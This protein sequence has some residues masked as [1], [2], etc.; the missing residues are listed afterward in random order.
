MLPDRIDLNLKTQGLGNVNIDSHTTNV[1]GNLRVEGETDLYNG[2]Y[3]HC[4]LSSE[5]DIEAIDS[6][7]HG[8]EL[9]EGGTSLA[10]KY[11][12]RQVITAVTDFNTLTTSGNYYIQYT[13]GGNQ[14][15]QNHGLLVCN[16]DCGTPFQIFYPDVT[17]TVYKRYRSNNV[18]SGWSIIGTDGIVT[19]SG[20]TISGNVML[21]GTKS[22]GGTIGNPWDAGIVLGADGHDKVVATYLGSATNGATIGA[23]TTNMDGWATLN[24]CGSQIDFRKGESRIA[25]LQEN[26]LTFEENEDMY[27]SNTGWGDR[28]YFAV[29]S[30]PDRQ[31][32]AAIG[33]T[34]GNLHLDPCNGD[35]G[36]YIGFYRGNGIIYF[37]NGNTG[38]QATMQNGYFSGNCNYANSC[39]NADTVDGLHESDFARMGYIQ[40]YEDF[41][42]ITRTGLYRFQNANPNNPAGDWGELQV[43]CG[44]DTFVQVAYGYGNDRV[45]FRT[46][47]Q[48]NGSV[49][50]TN[51]WYEY[52]TKKLIRSG[53]CTANSNT[54]KT[55]SF[56]YTFPSV[57]RIV[58][59]YS[60]TGGNIDGDRGSIKIHSI[61]QSE[62]KIVI[63]GSA[64]GTDRAIDWIAFCD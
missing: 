36:T 17:Q 44:H 21:G 53:S 35:Y 38:S 19:T 50:W 8:K 39:G 37:G 40:A 59:S 11:T 49:T 61:T 16:F 56:G 30:R 12:H 4:D 26:G 52:V 64:D 14:P 1:K 31:T 25:T 10:D 60:T 3:L 33:T 28:K 54:N 34:N 58:A 46:G 20:G 2:L 27:V 9:I 23:H 63:G 22:F 55:V 32:N 29:S 41:N 13:G 62:F 51:G 57:P 45:Y 15:V 6:H 5:G 7:I 42:N 43:I 24:I 48:A 47:N 18:W